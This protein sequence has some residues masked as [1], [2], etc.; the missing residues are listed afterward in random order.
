MK[1]CWP[2]LPQAAGAVE[3]AMRAT[4]TF[5]EEVL[6]GAVGFTAHVEIGE[7]EGG[8]TGWRN[9]SSLTDWRG[10][11]WVYLENKRSES[12]CGAAIDLLSAESRE[13]EAREPCGAAVD[14]LNAELREEEATR[15]CVL[16]CWESLIHLS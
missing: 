1:V 9:R 6:T 13:E 14:V 11:N 8:S 12:P 4:M 3:K 16:L 15:A 2:G 10:R 5:K 7:K